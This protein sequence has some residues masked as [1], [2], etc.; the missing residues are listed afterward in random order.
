MGLIPAR[1]AFVIM[2]HAHPLALVSI[3][4]KIHSNKIIIAYSVPGGGGGRGRCNL[5]LWLVK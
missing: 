2:A 4:S 1:L 3:T 5:D